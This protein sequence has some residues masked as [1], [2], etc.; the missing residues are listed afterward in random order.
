MELVVTMAVT[1]IILSGV[2]TL[3]RGAIITSNANFEMT[4][5]TQSMRNAQ[6]FLTRDI[7]MTANGMKGLS[8]VWLPTRFV[9]RFLTFQSA[10]AIDPASN[11]YVSVGTMITD[12]NVTPGIP[13]PNSNPPTTYLPLSDRITLLTVDPTFTAIPLTSGD[14]TSATGEIRVPASRIDEFSV[15]EIYFISNG[16]SAT[17]G[18]VTAV[19]T[20]G[21]RIVWAAGD[22]F[23]LNQ[24]G[25]MGALNA[26]SSVGSAMNLTRANIVQYFVDGDGK[27]VRRAFGVRSEGLID[28]V[29]SEHFVTLQFRYV[30]KPPNTST[31]LEQPIDTLAW[32]DS[33]LVRT[34]EI[35]IRVESAY[36]LQDGEKHQ[37][38]SVTAI[39]VRNLHF[40]EAI[41]PRDANGNTDLPNP[42]PT[43][44]II[45]TPTPTPSTPTPTPTVIT[46]TPTPSGTP[47]PTPTPTPTQTPTPTPT[48]TPATGE[49]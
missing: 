28:S 33:A 44:R 32:G 8:N 11:G 39:G 46:P 37:V 35:S 5:A 2:F 21:L 24:T 4:S 14:V 48:P 26:V 16:G 45:P 47:T 27:L 30:L 20:A 29:V 9:T 18:T 10:S 6:E 43:P 17:F 41:D 1:L 19:D 49:G 42:G 7:L 25:L 40:L 15:G 23:G 31:I 13:V 36:P 22:T 12:N 38:D 34:V 3:M